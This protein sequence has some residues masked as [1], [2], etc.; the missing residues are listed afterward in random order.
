MW[1]VCDRRF[2]VAAAGVVAI[3]ILFAGRSGLVAFAAGQ[4]TSG[5]ASTMQERVVAKE[6]EGL[7]ALK[8]GDI[9]H[10][11][12]LTAEDAIFVDP[13]GIASKAEVMKNVAGFRLTDF[14]IEDGIA[15]A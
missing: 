8:T 9:A 13:H 11:G 2:G 5:G 14:T 7:E 12:E 6:R 3:A 10:F 4:A 1:I 15:S